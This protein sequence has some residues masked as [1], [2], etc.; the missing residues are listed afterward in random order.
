MGATQGAAMIV[1]GKREWVDFTD[2][3][4]KDDDF[5]E[6]GRDYEAS[7]LFIRGNVGIG[8]AKVFPAKNF[9]IFGKKW[10]EDHRK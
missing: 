7:Q 4:Y 2:L 3:E 8:V 9:V 1:N 10:F 6:L 5:Q